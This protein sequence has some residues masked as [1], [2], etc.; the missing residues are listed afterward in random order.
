[1]DS[2][3]AATYFDANETVGLLR[4]ALSLYLDGSLADPPLVND[5]YFRDGRLWTVRKTQTFRLGTRRSCFWRCAIRTQ[6]SYP[7]SQVRHPSLRRKGEE[8]IESVALH[9]LSSFLALPSEGRVASLRRA[10]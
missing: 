4:P 7:G 10:G 2:G 9:F 3:T 8:G 6:K 5:I 1:M